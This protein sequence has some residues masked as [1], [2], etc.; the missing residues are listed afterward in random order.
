MVSYNG[1]KIKMKE[2]IIRKRRLKSRE[3][4]GEKEKKLI[5]KTKCDYEREGNSNI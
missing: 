3:I 1:G 2:L 5:T 4:G